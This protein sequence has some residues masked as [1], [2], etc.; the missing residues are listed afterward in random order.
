MKVVTGWDEIINELKNGPMMVG[1]MIYEDFLNYE[2]GV[3]K[4]TTGQ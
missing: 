3:Y 2:S 4:Q 1:L